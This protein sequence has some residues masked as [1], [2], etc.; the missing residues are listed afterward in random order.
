MM[1]AEQF[2]IGMDVGQTQDHTALVVNE[3]VQPLPRAIYQ[4]RFLKRFP[5]QTSYPDIFLA[6]KTLVE[7]P[8]L[9]NKSVLVVDATGVGLAISDML[10]AMK[11]PVK[12]VPMLIVGGNT[13][14]RD[15][16]TWHVPKR[17]LATAVKLVLER[18][19]LRISTQIPQYNLLVRELQAF[20]VKI[21]VSAKDTYEAWREKDHDDLVLATAIAVWYAERNRRKMLEGLKGTTVS[22]GTKI[23][24]IRPGIEEITVVRDEVTEDAKYGWTWGDIRRTH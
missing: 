11:L 23:E 12:L 3:R 16:M 20:R 17:D 4:L 14:S 21:S 10:K 13:V 7:H 24:P 15:G 19:A 2:F 8:T 5:L 9:A 1:D 22:D 6:I 18:E